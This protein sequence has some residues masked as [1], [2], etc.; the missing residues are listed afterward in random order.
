MLLRKF[1]FWGY[2]II[3]VFEGN[4]QQFAFCL[5]AEWSHASNLA[6]W[7]RGVKTGVLLFG[8]VTVIAAFGGTFI[9]RALYGRLNRHITDNN[10][11]HLRGT[12]VLLL[13]SGIR[14]FVLGILHSV[15]R[16]LP[17]EAMLSL[18]LITEAIFVTFLIAGVPL[19]AY[20]TLH[21]VW[22]GLYLSLVRIVLMLTFFF[23]YD[24]VGNSII[25]TVQSV[26]IIV[27]LM[28]YVIVT[29]V[30]VFETLF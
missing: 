2:F 1:D 18:L 24:D 6:P 8:F 27:M 26:L 15:L 30:H 19:K 20:R 25:E 17:Y 13:Q 22:A 16:P 7:Q 28:I 12:I 11:N 4:I 14:N 3:L 5:A 21:S 9:M 10:R 23:D 29:A